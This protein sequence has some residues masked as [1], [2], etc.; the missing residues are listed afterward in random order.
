MVV[1]PLWRKNTQGSEAQSS[2]DHRCSKFRF[3]PVLQ[4]LALIIKDHDS[5]IP[6]LNG[7]AEPQTIAQLPELY[8]KI[9][10]QGVMSFFA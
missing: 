7:I 9:Y 1:S 2:H 4:I 10:F 8:T 3:L 6:A 5:G